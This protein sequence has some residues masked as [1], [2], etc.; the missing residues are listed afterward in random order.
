MSD[1]DRAG[2]V[3]GHGSVSFGVALGGGGEQT[4]CRDT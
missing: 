2:A 4:D 1:E 3:R